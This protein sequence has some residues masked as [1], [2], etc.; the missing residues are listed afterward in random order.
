M[1]HLDSQGGCFSTGFVLLR[2]IVRKPRYI[3]EKIM[4]RI[5]VRVVV[6]VV[7]VVVV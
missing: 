5:V 1:A 6:V 3:V 2:V 4:L 7:V